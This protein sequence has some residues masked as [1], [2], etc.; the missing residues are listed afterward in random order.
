[1]KITSAQHSAITPSLLHR[2]AIQQLVL[3]KQK[4]LL[5]ICK[6]EIDFDCSE[7]TLSS[8][9]AFGDPK[10][11]RG[12]WVGKVLVAGLVEVEWVLIAAMI[13][14]EW[15]LVAG[16]AEVEKMLVAA[17]VEADKVAFSVDSIV[18]S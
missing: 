16:I 14:A 4:R 12:R 5:L 9:G 3:K 2:Q 18:I 6:I 17:M 7:H 11:R 15:V 1:M 10:R 13:E 8:C